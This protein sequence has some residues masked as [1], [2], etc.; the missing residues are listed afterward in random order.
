MKYENHCSRTRTERPFKMYQK[1]ERAKRV[2]WKNL[3]MRQNK[4]FH[5]KTQPKEKVVGVQSE[6]LK[7][8]TSTPK[9]EGKLEFQT[10]TFNQPSLAMYKQ[11]LAKT[12]EK[13]GRQEKELTFLAEGE[14]QCARCGTSHLTSPQP[15]SHHLTLSTS[16]HVTPPHFTPPGACTWARGPWWTWPPWRP[17]SPAP[18]APGPPSGGS[19]CSTPAQNKFEIKQI[20]SKVGLLHI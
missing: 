16:P 18:S 2:S 17:P 19:P 13:E 12:K 5:A 4:Q 20:E 9:Q 3:V 7:I 14:L 8:V 6:A 15:T 1:G 11:K 10:A